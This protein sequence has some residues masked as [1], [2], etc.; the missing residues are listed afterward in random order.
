M[1]V[2]WQVAPLCVRLALECTKHLADGALVF[3]VFFWHT[4]RCDESPS[5]CWLGAGILQLLAAAA[6]HHNHEC[7]CNSRQLE[8]Q[9]L[10]T[11]MLV[12]LL[13][14][15]FQS[16]G[17]LKPPACACRALQVP[18]PSFYTAS[19][20]GVVGSQLGQF[21]HKPEVLG[22]L[23]AGGLLHLVVVH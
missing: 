22:E 2:S 8:L 15:V 18:R 5:H 20:S 17:Q 19:M 23:L 1:H 9:K 10:H 14:S 13:P 7:G 21:G 3:A 12:S 4:E 16:S 11:T 6:P